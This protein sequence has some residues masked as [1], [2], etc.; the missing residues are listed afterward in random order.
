MLW[1]TLGGAVLALAVVLLLLSGRTKE[2]A[3]RRHSFARDDPEP[4]SWK[5]YFTNV[6]EAMPFRGVFAFSYKDSE[7]CHTNRTV[8]ALMLVP[9]PDRV[10]L[11]GFCRSRNEYRHFNLD[12]AT[13]MVDAESGESI[14]NP[15]VGLVQ[16]CLAQD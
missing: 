9:R 2:V 15:R 7:N 5:E 1:L 3:G 10:T 16:R 14:E 13:N 6:P 8:E 12:R 11:F 4:G